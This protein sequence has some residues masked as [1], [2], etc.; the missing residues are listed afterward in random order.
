VTKTVKLVGEV[1]LVGQKGH[2]E[3][4]D[5]RYQISRGEAWTDC[6]ANHPTPH[7]MC[8][9]HSYPYYGWDVWDVVADEYVPGGVMLDT[10]E[11][12]KALLAAHLDGQTA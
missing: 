1:K 8:L 6:D 5:G 3:T 2:Y 11:E 12:A 9:G 10:F 7:G 4:E